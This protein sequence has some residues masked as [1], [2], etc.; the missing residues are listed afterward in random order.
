MASDVG[1]V[2]GPD[3]REHL[4]PIRVIKFMLTTG[5]PPEVV[6]DREKLGLMMDGPKHLVWR[7]LKT[8]RVKR[9]P[10]TPEPVP[11]MTEF[12]ELLPARSEKTYN[13]MVQEVGVHAGVP[14]ATPRML[15]HTILSH[16]SDKTRDIGD[17]MP[18]GGCSLKVAVGHMRTTDS[19]RDK[20]ILVT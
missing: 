20:P 15:R 13:R 9:V 5:V 17:V 10:I 7:R 11:W 1:R 3:H 8:K 19:E 16:L 4:G 2:L 6:A 18:F 12:I 14:G